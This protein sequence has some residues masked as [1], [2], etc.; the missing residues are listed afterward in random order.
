MKRRLFPEK[1][2]S[3]MQL[4]LTSLK[5]EQGETEDVVGGVKMRHDPW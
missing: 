2:T 5:V 1:I 4:R 3:L